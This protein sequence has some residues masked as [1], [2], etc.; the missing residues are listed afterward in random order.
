MNDGTIKIYALAVCFASLMCGTIATG[1]FLFNVVKLVAPEATIDPNIIRQYSS[2]EV[3]R[4]SHY[5]NTGTRFSSYAIAP[6]G[7]TTAIGPGGAIARSVP[8]MNDQSNTSELSEEEIEKSRLQQLDAVISSHKFRARQGIILQII[9]VLI[10]SVLFIAHWKL[11]KK[12]NRET[13]T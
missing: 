6:G 5:F 4:N 3:F 7:V 2:D 9:I 10:S 11:A 8:L 13:S 1:F 12:L